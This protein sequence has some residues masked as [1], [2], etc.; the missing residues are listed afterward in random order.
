MAPKT[1]DHDYQYLSVYY[2]AFNSDNAN[3]MNYHA[4]NG[5]VN[6][7]GRAL[8]GATEFMFDMDNEDIERQR[9]NPYQKAGSAKNGIRPENDHQFQ[10]ARRGIEEMTLLFGQLASDKRMSNYP[11]IKSY[12]QTNAKLMRYANDGRDMRNE[13]ARIPGGTLLLDGMVG[14]KSNSAENAPK[15]METM[16]TEM[17][18]PEYY[19]SVMNYIDARHALDDPGISAAE[20]AKNTEIMRASLMNMEK[21]AEHC[22]A[23]EVEE[24]CSQYYQGFDDVV[25]GDRG[26]KPLVIAPI[27]EGLKALDNGWDPAYVEDYSQLK[28][29]TDMA[30][31]SMQVMESL[32]QALEDNNDHYAPGDIQELKDAMN[33]LAEL[34]PENRVFK[35]PAEFVKYSQSVS[36][37]INTVMKISEKSEVQDMLKEFSDR[38]FYNGKHVDND[39]N[40]AYHTM[41]PEVLRHETSNL[42]FK[43]QTFLRHFENKLDFRSRGINV[44]QNG[45]GQ[46]SLSYNAQGMQNKTGDLA[47]IK[48]SVKDIKSHSKR[49]FNDLN[50]DGDAEGV[51]AEISKELENLKNMNAGKVSILQVNMA[52]DKISKLA[53]V[54]LAEPNDRLNGIKQWADQ[55]RM[56]LRQNADFGHIDQYK[57][58]D[59]QIQEHKDLVESRASEKFVQNNRGMYPKFKIAPLDL[60]IDV[61]VDRKKIYSREEREQLKNN[62][63]EALDAKDNNDVV[64]IDDIDVRV[65]IPKVKSML[66]NGWDPTHVDNAFRYV[67]LSTISDSSLDKLNNFH[68]PRLAHLQKKITE[69]KKVFSKNGDGF[70]KETDFEEFFVRCSYTLND[71]VREAKKPEVREAL[72][73][74]A[75]Y[76][77]MDN[78]LLKALVSSTNDLN[79]GEN[80]KFIKEFIA[81]SDLTRERFSGHENV[82]EAYKKVELEREKSALKEISRKAREKLDYFEQN[83]DGQRTRNSDE[84]IL[85]KRSLAR[86]A[87]LS[88]GNHTP[89]HVIEALNDMKKYAGKYAATRDGVFKHNNQRVVASKALVSLANEALN[90]YRNVGANGISNFVDV[91]TQKKRY[92]TKHHVVKSKEAVN[93]ELFVKI[94]VMEGFKTAIM[95]A[96]EKIDQL[97]THFNN[98]EAG[99]G[100]RNTRSD[101]YNKLT[102][103]TKKLALL[104]SHGKDAITSKTPA[105]VYNYMRNTMYA[106]KK[107]IEEH[108][109]LSHPLSATHGVGED[110]LNWAKEIYETL[111]NEM[112]TIDMAYERV[113]GVEKG[114]SI[115]DLEV[116]YRERTLQNNAMIQDDDNNIEFNIDNE[117]DPDLNIG[118]GMGEKDPVDQE[119]NI[120]IN[121]NNVIHMDE[122]SSFSDDDEKE[123][124]IDI[125]QNNKGKGEDNKISGDDMK[126]FKEERNKIQDNNKQAQMNNQK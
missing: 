12:V 9:P 74:Y 98:D 56:S 55:C 36:D 28:H 92:E 41:F 18:F 57:P 103:M 13:I 44:I 87:G 112:S 111:R 115:S 60:G 124:V 107:Y 24:K 50:R 80:A 71:V 108:T 66:Q 104:N 88:E 64:N 21:M 99:R 91:E 11:A 95:N 10:M 118:G 114:K 85:M 73:L 90:D 101:S 121:N 22:L 68:D 61:Y 20:K 26:Y 35:S 33:N 125:S 37:A 84:Y 75:G 52:L 17:H 70:K 49:L 78:T 27:Q 8:R 116:Q 25:T 65:E 40:K 7:A 93:E 54:P 31:D 2:Q 59:D 76:P 69:M 46:V 30:K 72:E 89:A 43:N 48:N 34:S 63:I 14:W 83:L 105:A 51:E 94:G 15:E 16:L 106:A 38:G 119:L 58:I 79:N 117:N 47:N 45:N 122:N 19:K 6:G 5:I 96:E 113:R 53:N 100:A 32:E 42:Y 77:D 62:L 3:A 86:V 109:G 4:L 1:Y 82:R 67:R 39:D 81:T 123:S 102:D 23:P 110:R 97:V 29:I 126:K 120:N